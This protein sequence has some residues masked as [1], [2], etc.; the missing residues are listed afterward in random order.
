MRIDP[1]HAMAALLVATLT[2]YAVAAYFPSV[3]EGVLIAAGEAATSHVIDWSN[4]RVTAEQLVEDS[5]LRGASLQFVWI[6]AVAVVVSAYSATYPLETGVARFEVQLVG[7]RTKLIVN[8]ITYAVVVILAPLVSAAVVTALLTYGAAYLEPAL[9]AAAAYSL[10]M[11][12]LVMLTY[13]A[14]LVAR[15]LLPAIISGLAIFYVYDASAR[16]ALLMPYS[17]LANTGLTGLLSTAIRSSIPILVASSAS[18][19]IVLAYASARLEV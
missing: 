12:G 7:T 2:A 13:A 16:H 19:G 3:S 11:L 4:V 5:I 14:A 9:E 17:V 8:G 1:V 6:G 10:F 15:R 18:L